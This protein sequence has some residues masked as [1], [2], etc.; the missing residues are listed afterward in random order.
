MEGA[1]ERCALNHSLNSRSIDPASKGQHVSGFGSNQEVLF[2][3]GTFYTGLPGPFE[4]TC[5][6]RPFLLKVQILR[7]GRSVWILAI[8]DPLTGNAGGLLLRRWLLGER[9]PSCDQTKTNKN[10][11]IE[12]RLQQSSGPLGALVK[13]YS[14]LQDL[15]PNAPGRTRTPDG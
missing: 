9:C 12:I 3:D 4:V 8:Q 5:N 6:G 13:I 14:N 15:S 1:I 10:N 7:R 11:C 2:I